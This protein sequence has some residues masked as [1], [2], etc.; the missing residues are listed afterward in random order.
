MKDERDQKNTTVALSFG[1]CHDFLSSSDFF[2][3]VAVRSHSAPHTEQ[4]GSQESASQ[5]AAF[6]GSLRRARVRYRPDRSRDRR[7]A[8]VSARPANPSRKT[9]PRAAYSASLVSADA[10]HPLTHDRSARLPR[11]SIDITVVIEGVRHKLKGKIGKTLAQALAE[12]NDPELLAVV[13]DVSLRQGPDTHVSLPSD[14]LALM[15]EL[16]FEGETLLKDI[17]ENPGPI[18]RMASQVVLSKALDGMSVAI[19]ANR[20]FPSGSAI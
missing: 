4:H 17:A 15:P 8:I 1:V 7:R 14:V 2:R 6:D 12:S 19:A 3:A 18:S 13:P 9:S 10:T 20:P 11:R 5:P 16:D